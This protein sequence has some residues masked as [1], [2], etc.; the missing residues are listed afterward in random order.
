MWNN[1]FKKLFVEMYINT[2]KYEIPRDPNNFAFHFSL[3]A[4]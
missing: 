4:V 1:G 3:T 2:V